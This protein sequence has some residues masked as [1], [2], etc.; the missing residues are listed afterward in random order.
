EAATPLFLGEET[1]PV[2][3]A[4]SGHLSPTNPKPPPTP[5]PPTFFIKL[6]LFAVLWTVIPLAALLVGLPAVPLF[7]LNHKLFRSFVRHIERAAGAFM[8]ITAFLF[9]PGSWLIL[10]GD[11]DRMRPHRKQVVFANHQIYS[12]WHYLWMLAWSKHCHADFR[13]MMLKVIRM[14]P[15]IG[16]V[17]DLFEFIFLNQKLDLDRPLIERNLETARREKGLPLWMLLFPEGGVFWQGGMER[18]KKYAE[19]MCISPHPVH[20]MLPKST[21]LF[22]TINSLHPAATD[23]FDATVGYSGL[24]ANDIPYDKYTPNRVYLDGIYPREVH[25][26]IRHFTVSEIP[27]F[28]QFDLMDP[29]HERRDKF[30]VWLRE[31]YMQKD[32]RLTEFYAE[33]DLRLSAKE[34]TRQRVALIPRSE[35]WIYFVGL[36]GAF[37]VLVPWYLW[38][39]GWIVFGVAKAIY[40]VM[41]VVLYVLG[42][43][44][45]IGWAGMLT[46]LGQLE[47]KQ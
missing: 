25:I 26:H 40:L 10:T 13:I 33:G 35:D 36:L 38:G 2:L 1:I 17:L 43:S 18:S 24:T 37:W 7:V 27:G 39:I 16:Q 9:L 32:Q 22:L 4:P 28:T 30:D 21:G 20:C 8:T 6:F 29:E 47:K 41:Q 23:V 46:F 12:D 34:T 3:Q 44:R 42:F 31:V 19:K 15:L 14:V 5:K 45:L 11:F